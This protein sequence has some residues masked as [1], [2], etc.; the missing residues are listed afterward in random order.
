MSWQRRLPSRTAKRGWVHD[1]LLTLVLAAL[2]MLS[3]AG[4]A[5]SQL[6]EVADRAQ[7]HGQQFSFAEY[8]PAFASATLENWQSEF[9]QLFTFVLLTA[10]LIHR[11]SA[12]S[13]DGDDELKGMLAELLERTEHLKSEEA[14]QHLPPA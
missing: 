10:H 11:N 5:I 3:W 4:Q 1:H 2:F 12:E 6:V 13:P 9:L 14:T 8:W 7:Q